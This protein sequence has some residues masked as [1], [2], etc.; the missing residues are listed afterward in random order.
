MKILDHIGFAISYIFIMFLIALICSFVPILNIVVWFA[1]GVI[2]LA[3]PFLHSSLYK[4]CQQKE[5]ERL[6]KEQIKKYKHQKDLQ[7]AKTS[8]L[9][10]I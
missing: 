9:V 1:T 6:E 7:E 2:L 10:D 5:Q 8:K 4:E 3:Y